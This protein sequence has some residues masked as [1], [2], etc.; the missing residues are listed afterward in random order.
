M[1][2]ML[3]SRNTDM[4]DRISTTALL[5][6]REQY[7]ITCRHN[8]VR[9]QIVVFWITMSWGFVSG[10]RVS[11]EHAASNFKVENNSKFFKTNTVFNVLCHCFLNNLLL[12]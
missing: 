10:Y 5:E 9:N 7:I 3:F 2:H 1:A 6:T 12:E 11:E 4:L 8:Y